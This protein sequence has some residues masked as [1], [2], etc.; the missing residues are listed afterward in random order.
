MPSTYAKIW[1]ATKFQPWG[2]PRSGSKAIKREKERREKEQKLVITMANY[3]LQRHFG[4]P[5]PGP[6]GIYVL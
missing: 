4:L 5:G 2:F 6:I 3:A 1:G